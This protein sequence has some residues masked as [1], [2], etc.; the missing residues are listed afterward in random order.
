MSRR[1]GRR[2]NPGGRPPK[3]LDKR[4]AWR[5]KVAIRIDLETAAL[6]QRLMLQEWPGVATVEDLVA[7]ALRRLENHA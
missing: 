5:G 4:A 3:P 7:Y 2:S 1:G 6:A